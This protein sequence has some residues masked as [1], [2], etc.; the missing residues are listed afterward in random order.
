M[1]GKKTIKE[2]P[3]GP[4]SGGQ[5]AEAPMKERTNNIPLAVLQLCLA[6]AVVGYAA[7]VIFTGETLVIEKRERGAWAFWIELL[8]CL[9]AMGI[10]LWSAVGNYNR[11]LKERFS[12]AL[13]PIAFL[14]T[15]IGLMAYAV[16]GLFT[17][18]LR[19]LRLGGPVPSQIDYYGPAV[20]VLF[21]AYISL[22]VYFISGGVKAYDKRDREAVYKKIDTVTLA[23]ALILYIAAAVLASKLNLHH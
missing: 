22:S 6:V 7:Y 10:L 12:T 17:N 16:Y 3:I 4:S 14:C 23:L 1:P 9:V 8:L 5:K 21:I 18:K 15:G 2:K 13:T 20:W 19:V 11:D